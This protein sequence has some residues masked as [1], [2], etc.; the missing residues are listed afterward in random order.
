MESSAK[1]SII[2]A[3]YNGAEYIDQCLESVTTQSLKEIEVLCVDD[4]STDNSE[5]LLQKWADKDNRIKIIKQEN[6]G[7]GFARN[8]GLAHATGEFIAFLDVDDL[9]PSNDVLEMLYNLTQKYH[10]KAAGGSLQILKDGMKYKGQIGGIKYFFNEEKVITFEELQQGFYYQRFIYSREVLQ[11]NNIVFPYYKRFQDPPFFI[12]A[13]LACGDIAVM[14]EYSYLYRQDDTKWNFTDEKTNHL[15]EGHIEVLQL[16]ADHGL[17]GLFNWCVSRI[18]SNSTMHHIIENSLMNGNERIKPLIKEFRD[19]VNNNR[20][21]LSEDTELNYM[22]T[23]LIDCIADTDEEVQA[24]IDKIENTKA[25]Y[26][27]KE[28]PLVSIVV[29]IYNVEQ[30]LNIALSSILNQ[31]YENIELICVNDETKD[32]SMEIV[33]K[34]AEKDKRVIIVEQKNQGLSGARNTGLMHAKGKYIQFVDSDDAITKHGLEYFVSVAEQN[35]LDVLAFNGKTIFENYQAAFE[36]PVYLHYYDN[37]TADNGVFNGRKLF[38]SLLE[39][40]SYRTSVPLMLLKTEFLKDKNL[41]FEKGIVHE[42][43]LFT[44]LVYLFAERAQYVEDIGYIRRVRSDS[45]MT[46][47]AAF[48]NVY[49]YFISYIKSLSALHRLELNEETESFNEFLHRTI[50][51]ARNIYNQLD[52]EERLKA[53]EIPDYY[54]ADFQT[55][56]LD[57]QRYRDESTE[58]RTKLKEA[59]DDKSLIRARLQEAWDEKTDINRKLQKTYKEKSEIN[60]KLQQ[61]YKEKAERGLR[62]KDLEKQLNELKGQNAPLLKKIMKK[63]K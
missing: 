61:T 30:F 31:S 10:T 53:E 52:E 7:A 18:E 46:K 48:K 34:W 19:I 27:L 50:T 23:F 56:I 32:N 35:N 1:V 38:K 57:M 22:D 59:W 42:D 36:Q 5:E 37:R 13:M 2:I 51:N 49:G 9:Y 6:Q 16:C 40:N 28:K 62:I 43:N 8:N 44:F 3:I 33:R 14:K 11:S 25:T 58:L 12:R 60:Q 20:H 4:G 45:I 63:I 54:K 17:E 15:L 55:L 41:L 47:K 24:V 39:N 21:L 29:P 26:T